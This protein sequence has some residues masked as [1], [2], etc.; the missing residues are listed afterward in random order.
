[1]PY[2]DNDMKAII[3][4][5]MDSIE[6]AMYTVVGELGITAYRTKEPVPFSERTSGERLDLKIGDSWG[7]KWDCA[8]FRF[9]GTAI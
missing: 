8:W 2:L 5:R 1:M 3:K 6:S 7:E 9:T 4:Y